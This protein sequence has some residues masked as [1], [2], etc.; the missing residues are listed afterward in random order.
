MLP[1]LAAGDPGGHC[2][3]VGPRRLRRSPVAGL[4]PRTVIAAAT[5]LSSGRE[6]AREPTEA[7]TALS[8]GPPSPRSADTGWSET[9]LVDWLSPSASASTTAAVASSA[10]SAARARVRWARIWAPKWTLGWVT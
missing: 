3:L 4:T 6:A 5:L 2:A 8:S 9:V 10:S 1:V 7:A